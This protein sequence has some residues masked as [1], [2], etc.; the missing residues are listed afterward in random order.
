MKVFPINR[1]RCLNAFKYRVLLAVKSWPQQFT[2]FS[3]KRKKTDTCVICNG[4]PKSGTYLIHKIVEY[5]DKWE[6]IK[7]HIGRTNWDQAGDTVVHINN[8]CM[9]KY[10][11]KKLQNGQFVGAHIPWRR[12]IQMSMKNITSGR[13]IKHILIYRDPRDTFI[14]SMNY[15]THSNKFGGSIEAVKLKKFMLENFSNDDDRL[16]YIIE[17][18]RNQNF[19]EYIGWFNSPYCHVVRFEDLYLDIKEIRDGIPGETLLNLFEYLEVDPS[20]VDLSAFYRNVFCKGVT[21]SEVVDKTGQYKRV[22]KE[23]HYK[24]LDNPEFRNVLNRLGYQW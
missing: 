2:P 1:K 14:S 4:I 10:S 18:E 24:L 17:Q 8:Y 20:S 7:V 13:R 23:Q 6:D 19:L 9:A 3:Y 15:V 11:V 12:G 21:A 22:Y 5:I 16:T